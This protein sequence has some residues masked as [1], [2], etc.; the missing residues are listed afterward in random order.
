MQ[1]NN[2]TRQCNGTTQWNNTKTMPRQCQMKQWNDKRKQRNKSI[3]QQCKTMQVTMEM[4]Q[5]LDDTTK[6]PMQHNVK[7]NNATTWYA[8]HDAMTWCNNL[9]QWLDAMMWCNDLMMQQLDQ[10]WLDNTQHTTQW[11]DNAMIWQCND[12]T[13]QWLDNAMTRQNNATHNATDLTKQQY[14][15]TETHNKKKKD[16]MQKT[17]SHA[18][19]Q[20]HMQGRCINQNEPMKLTNWQNW[21]QNKTNKTDDKKNTTT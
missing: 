11:L 9:M 12:L 20:H 13:M 14:A 10:M 17:T 18:M 5:I 6:K 2:A 3:P 21:W 1:W 4:M 8:T 7:E 16:T 19:T 15:M